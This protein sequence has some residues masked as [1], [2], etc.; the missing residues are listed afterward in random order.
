MR[1]AANSEPGPEA[2]GPR[3]LAAPC[4][5]LRSSLATAL[6][7]RHRTLEPLLGPA[8]P[9]GQGA[10]APPSPAAG[11]AALEHGEAQGPARTPRGAENGQA[12]AQRKAQR[13]AQA[14]ARVA[15]REAQLRARVDE[16]RLMEEQFAAQAAQIEDIQRRLEGLNAEKH[17]AV[18][19]LKQA[20]NWGNTQLACSAPAF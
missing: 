15:D 7:R 8:T 5:A 20:R 19:K 10:A 2:A 6:A 9:R 17:E 13:K 3:E 1:G 16:K 11:S 18:L 4:P 14:Q 12:R